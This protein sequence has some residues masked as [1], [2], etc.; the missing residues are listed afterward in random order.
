MN[1]FEELLNQAVNRQSVAGANV[2]VLK[3]GVEVLYAEAGFQDLEHH[4]PMKRDTI[5]RL[6]SQTK[7]ITAAAVVQLASR[8]IVD[9]G[10]YVSDY[11]PEFGASYLTVNG[12]RTQTQNI[13]VRDL[14]NMTSGIPYPDTS[15]SGMQSGAVFDEVIRRLYTDHPVTTAE[16]SEKMSKVDLKFEPGSRFD[17]GASADILGALVERVSGMSFGSFLKKEF[18]EPLEMNDTDFYVP[19]EKA[20]RLAKVYDYRRNENGEELIDST[21]GRLREV[22]TDH[23]G[24]RYLRD[25]PPSFESGGAGLCST[26]DDYAKFATMLLKQG[27]YKGKEIMSKSAVRFLTHGG[28]SPAMRPDWQGGW[29]WMKG[30]TYGNLMRVLK[31]EDQTCIFTGKG[32]YGWDGWL[33]THFSNEPEYRL[34]FLVGVQQVGLGEA[35]TLTHKLKNAVMSRFA[36]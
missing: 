20:H 35:A 36:K 11:L 23:L 30:Y 22:V 12:V 34:T 14:M 17:Y 13:T 6:Y 32:E 31:D 7:P 8:G 5:F 15:D 25:V 10:G 33:G 3:D 16:F 26:L 28:L 24:L 19:K 2:L 9:I 4:I 27:T 18:F 21:E 1:Q 29:D